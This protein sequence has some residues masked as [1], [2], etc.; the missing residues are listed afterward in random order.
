MA[1]KLLVFFLPILI[2]TNCE[3]APIVESKAYFSG[4]TLI[5]ELSYQDLPEKNKLKRICDIFLDFGNFKEKIISPIV[6]KELVDLE[7][8]E[9]F[10]KIQ[11]FDIDDCPREIIF[12]YGMHRSFHVYLNS[13]K[14]GNI[15]V[16]IAR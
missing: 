4:N 2:F 16:R 10:L 12:D 9:S 11:F 5:L 1:R 14:S 3:K 6:E 7:Q 13:D 8:E 15:N